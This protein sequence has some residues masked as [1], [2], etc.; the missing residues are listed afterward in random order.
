MR[1]PILTTP[2]S[3]RPGFGEVP[4]MRT[5]LVALLLVGGAA[6][7]AQAQSSDSSNAASSE[8]DWLVVPYAS[9]S[10][11]TKIAVGGGGGYYLSAPSGQAPSSVE[12]SLNATQRRQ[13]SAG[14]DAELYLNDEEWRLQGELR[15]SKYPSSF[16]GIGGDTP[17]AAEESYT[18]RYGVFD[19]ILQHRLRPNLHVGPRLFVR[20]GAITD[21][22]ANGLIENDRVA[23]ANGGTTAGV[24][25][26]TLWDARDNHYYPTS[27]T[28]GELVTT[29]YSA[30]WGSDYTYAYLRTD[31]RGYR[32]A[33]IGVLAAQVYAE[34]VGGRAP[35]LLLPLLG[36][37][38]QMR[39]YRKGRF[40]ED[41]L[42]ALQTEYRF[43]LF[44]RFKGTVFGS[45]GEVAPRIGSTLFEGVEAAVGVG[46]R[47]RLTD[48]GIHGRL[49]VA[50]SRTGVEIYMSLGEAF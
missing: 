25:F 48:S 16:H 7:L 22:E 26:S 13:I 2:S 36:G 4:R 35:F 20:V 33:G 15:G 11:T 19:L 32:P 10:P 44:W 8:A 39:G 43:P 45:A 21:P 40:R 17:E 30:A 42:W 46:G 31:L 5:V 28:Y 41:V 23:G 1:R 24:G 38:D 14:V 47:F 27:G 29:W 50:Y 37:A 9:Y 49:D 12:M 6:S 18:A 34:L 3:Y